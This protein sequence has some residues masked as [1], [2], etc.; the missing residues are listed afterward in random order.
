MLIAVASQNFRTVTGHAGKS[1]RFLVFDAAF[2]RAPRE[3]RRLDLPKEQSIHEF[4]ERS[5]HPLDHV[6]AV[7]AGSAGEGFV[8]RMAAR[9]VRAVTTAETDEAGKALLDA[10]GFPF[11]R[12]ADAG[13]APKK[14]RRGGPVR[15]GKGPKSAPAKGSKK[16]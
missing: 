14:K 11:K 6:E 9:G 13:P 7:I 12:G 4:D 16:K 5:P 10:F 1:R 8:K 2:G 3:I 15:G